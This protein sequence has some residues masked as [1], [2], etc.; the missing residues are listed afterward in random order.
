MREW[1]HKAL[2]L[3]ADLSILRIVA[4]PWGAEVNEYA[5]A[6]F[7]RRRKCTGGDRR[8]AQDSKVVLRFPLSLS[9]QR[10]P[11]RALMTMFMRIVGSTVTVRARRIDIAEFME[12]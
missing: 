4:S 12:V 10:N 3:S 6:D 9:L 1:A 8:L 11:S 2:G 5:G 7:D